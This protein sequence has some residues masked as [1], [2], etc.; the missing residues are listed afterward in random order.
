[1][2][3]GSAMAVSQP[4][5]AASPRW[6]MAQ[7]TIGS[8]FRRHSTAPDLWVSR[9]APQ[10]QYYRPFWPH[11]PFSNSSWHFNFQLKAQ[12]YHWLSIQLIQIGFLT[13]SIQ[14]T[15]SYAPF[16]KEKERKPT[17]RYTW[18]SFGHIRKIQMF[19]L[20][21]LYADSGVVS[22]EKNK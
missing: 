7:G 14:L 20:R 9:L 17:W 2:A 1:M 10:M 3:E 19:E 8:D 5:A 15:E 16:M 12:S 22:K 4:A 18:G 11:P 21:Q 6:G 13:F